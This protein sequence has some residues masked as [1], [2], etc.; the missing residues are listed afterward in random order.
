MLFDLLQLHLNNTD[1]VLF[2]VNN[3][4]TK[5]GKEKQRFLL[6]LI[7][8]LLKQY[9]EVQ[10]VTLNVNGIEYLERTWKTSDKEK[11]HEDLINI[12]NGAFSTLFRRQQEFS[13]AD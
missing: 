11:N 6:C 9:E 12:V 10:K 8:N 1:W 13:P 2:P 7:T 3:I 5:Q 4:W